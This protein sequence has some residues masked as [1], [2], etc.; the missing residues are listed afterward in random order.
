MHGV[1][2][3]PRSFNPQRNMITTKPTHF[4]D[5]IFQNQNYKPTQPIN[6]NFD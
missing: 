2:F 6:D 4:F 3:E 5:Y 1:G